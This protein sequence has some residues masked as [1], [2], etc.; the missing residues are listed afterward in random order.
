MPNIK[1]E[2]SAINKSFSKAVS[3]RQWSMVREKAIPLIIPPVVVAG[4]LFAAMLGA[5][6]V[7]P[8]MGQKIAVM[9][10]A[11]A[12]AAT[13]LWSLSKLF[14]KNSSPFISKKRAINAIDD[15]IG[16]DA[17]PARKMVDK[18]AA[19]DKEGWDDMFDL[20]KK[21][22]W[23]EHGEQISN[24]KRKIGL[25]QYYN[26]GKSFKAIAHGAVLS[27]AIATASFNGDGALQK[28]TDAWNYVPPPPPLSYTAWVTPPSRISDAPIYQDGMLKAT[29]SENEDLPAHEGSILSIVTDDRAGDIFVNGTLLQ[30]EETP[31]DLRNGNN[32]APVRFTYTVPLNEGDITI[33]IEG[34]IYN[35]DVTPDN[36]P[37]IE[38][39]NSHTDDLDP[40]SLV[41]EYTITDDFGAAGAEIN[42]GV[43]NKDG[44]PAA[45]L[46]PSAQIPPIAIPHDDRP[47]GP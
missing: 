30:P 20:R 18:P 34:H 13:G 9:G 1:N 25:G 26:N 3:K 5:W 8:A 37:N 33:N 7:L 2:M 36:P 42:I 23:S 29:L 11:A 31:A 45:P 4:G 15:D 21:Q 43:R 14:N 6:D 16:G 10:S 12:S 39:L 27:A 22:V 40:N 38:I 24:Q 44:K 46:L 35:F 19:I 32:N 17:M 28:F 47:D 41:L